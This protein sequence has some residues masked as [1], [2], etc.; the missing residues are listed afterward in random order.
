[1]GILNKSTRTL[2]LVLGLLVLAACGGSPA[3]VEL[4]VD[5]YL[6]PDSSSP[7]DVLLQAAIFKRIAESAQLQEEAIHVRAFEA[8]VFLSGS[9][10]DACSSSSAAEIASTTSVTVGD[11]PSPVRA[12]RV[13]NHIEVPEGEECEG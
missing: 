11:N 5:L 4:D 9:V 12:S 1:M 10:R 2:I 7:D 6:H 8:V 3:R 13:E